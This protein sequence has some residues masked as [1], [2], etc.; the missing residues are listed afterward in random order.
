[1][2]AKAVYPF[3]IGGLSTIVIVLIGVIIYSYT[4]QK[5]HD[6]RAALLERVGHH[7]LLPSDTPVIAEV[8]DVEKL[9]SSLKGVAQKGDY[10][11]IFESKQKTIVYR[12]GVDKI[13]DV[14]T[15]L[16]GTQPNAAL[17]VTVTIYNGSGKNEVLERFISRLY[18]SYPNVQL[19]YKDVAPRE[20]PATI[21]YAA[22]VSQ[23]LSQQIA[24]TLGIKAGIAPNGLDSQGADV[25]FVIGSDYSQ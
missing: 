20:F 14:Q 16:F 3:V 10:I 8:V 19:I 7:M 4:A 1:V 24:Q 5:P 6:D 17:E 9:Q 13:I 23:E 22:D 2:R 12:P 18:T 21:V 25:V 15:I 11:L